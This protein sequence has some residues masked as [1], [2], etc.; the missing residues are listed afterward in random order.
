MKHYII[1]LLLINLMAC[2]KQDLE[3]NQG[4]QSNFTNHIQFES[5]QIGQKSTYLGFTAAGYG[6][7]DRYDDFQY[8]GDTLKLEIVDQMGHNFIV[9]QQ[10]TG[11]NEEYTFQ[12][13][14]DQ[15]ELVI[16]DLDPDIYTIEPFLYWLGLDGWGLSDT[17]RLNLTTFTKEVS[18]KGWQIEASPENGNYA[19]LHAE[20]VEIL[21]NQFSNINIIVDNIPMQVDGSGKTYLYSKADGFV[22]TTTY[23]PWT[24]EG[25][26]W[27][28]LH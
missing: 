28:L 10:M 3:E 25:S 5:P 18:I 17:M 6:D 1:L 14:I 7:P 13:Y 23:S 24:L 8:N 16:T 22:R 20:E 9:H 4:P 26:G 15:E 12:F 11:N 21:G 19:L 2:D 27:D